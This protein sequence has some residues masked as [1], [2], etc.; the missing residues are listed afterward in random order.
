M[1]NKHRRYVFLGERKDKRKY[2]DASLRK[3]KALNA[4]STRCQDAFSGKRGRP[5]R[6][7]EKRIDAVVKQALKE[8]LSAGSG[9]QSDVIRTPPVIRLEGLKATKIG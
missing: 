3:K 7:L 1:K 5:D 6:E 8:Q 2:N 4:T 9:Q